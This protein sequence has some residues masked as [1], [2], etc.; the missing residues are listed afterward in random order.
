MSILAENR[1]SKCLRKQESLFIYTLK[2]AGRHLG[3]IVESFAGKK[4]G[5]LQRRLQWKVSG[6]TEELRIYIGG[7]EGKLVRDI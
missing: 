1:L 2:A 5:G 3:W 4:D 6:L 7:I